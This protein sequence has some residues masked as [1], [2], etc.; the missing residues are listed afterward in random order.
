MVQHLQ[1]CKIYKAEFFFLDQLLGQ[2]AEKSSNELAT[3][4]MS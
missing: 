1:I 4:A 3:L 2:P